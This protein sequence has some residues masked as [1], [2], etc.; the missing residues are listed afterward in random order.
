MYILL[1]LSVLLTLA[2]IVLGIFFLLFPKKSEPKKTVEQPKS[3]NVNVGTVKDEGHDPWYAFGLVDHTPNLIR[4]VVAG[5]ESSGTILRY[6]GNLRN[7]KEVDPKT[8][9]VSEY[10]KKVNPETG[11]VERCENPFAGEHPLQTIVRESFGKL[12]YG[13]PKFRNIKP[14]MIDRVAKKNTGASKAKPDEQ[15]ETSFVRRYGLYQEF[16]RPTEHPTVDTKDGM[17]FAV[18]SNAL[19]KVTDARPAFEMFTDSL[20]QTISEIISGFVS[21]KVIDLEWEAYKKAGEKGNK[22]LPAELDE[23]NALLI[24]LGV[25]V[26][27]LTMSDPVV[28]PEMQKA[29]ELKK[30]AEEE[31]KAKKLAG[32]AQRQY[33]TDVGEGEAA[34]IE[35]IAK[36]KASRFEELIKK[37]T[38]ID[39]KTGEPAYTRAEAIKMANDMISMEFNAEAISKLTG[40]YVAGG[41]GVQLGIQGGGKQ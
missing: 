13:V 40:T 5:N 19:I 7:D 3:A 32:Q 29:L 10:K 24:P 33:L 4:A 39:L 1:G 36:A 38:E 37:Y 6:M 21:T 15:L 30:T 34:A 16:L 23:L 35:S 9:K 27:Q 2:L 22:F 26:T 41:T 18:T 17:R 14:L 11:V 31:A 28:N 20:L 25:E 8:G 12:F